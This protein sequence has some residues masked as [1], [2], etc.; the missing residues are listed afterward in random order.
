MRTPFVQSVLEALI[1]EH[2][3]DPE[4][5]F[6]AVCAG[7]AERDLFSKMQFSNVVIS[8][9]DERMSG[10]QFAPFAWS[11]QDAQDLSYED[12]AFEWVFVADGLHHCSSPHRALLEMYRVAKKGIIVVESRDSFVMRWANR[13]GL[14]PEY[15]LEAV[16]GHNFMYGGL[17]NTHIPNFIYRWTE[18]EFEKTIHSFDPTGAHTFRFFYGLNLPY[19]TAGFKKNRLK[20]YVIKG[21][22]P[23]LKVFTLLFKKQC[24]SF[25]MVAVKPRIPADL[26]PW[27][28]VE[29]GEVVFDQA[30]ARAHFKVK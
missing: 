16:I 9:L 15:E 18:A 21:V 27:L 17:N 23:L 26:Q 3:V 25:A 1:S 24:N 2:T 11:F 5:S 13:L 30:Y 10:D 19:E 12:G 7:E 20:Y 8:N 14:S 22:E 28:K 29:D 4:A 6:L